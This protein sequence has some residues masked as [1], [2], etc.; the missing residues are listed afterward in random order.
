MKKPLLCLVSILVVY[1][2]FLFSGS[3]FAAEPHEILSAQMVIDGK[4]D[5]DLEEKAAVF[6]LTQGRIG[7]GIGPYT[8][9]LCYDAENIYFAC[10]AKD[11]VVSCKDNVERDF[12]NSDYIRFYICVDDD[13]KGRQA[14]NGKSDWA[15]IFTPQDTED[16]WKPM[17]K[18]CPYNG[19]GH[20]AIEGD[21]IT[22]KRASG[23]G[24]DGWFIEAAL[25]FSLFDTTYDELSGR[26]FGVYFVA[27]DTD[28]SGART[29]E[30]SMQG[31]GAGNYWNS[32]DFWQ[33]SKLGEFI[34]VDSASKVSITWG[35]IKGRIP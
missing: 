15:I 33:E 26:I 3:T 13:F 23:P 9:Y 17:V 21:D 1:F 4:P 11:D 16:N 7:G 28:K 32:P 35:W 10:N 25:P 20:G 24:D 14:L 27:G 19:P 8:A 34:A 12:M 29:G 5:A 6:E 31:P 22:P 30:M 18:E 2:C